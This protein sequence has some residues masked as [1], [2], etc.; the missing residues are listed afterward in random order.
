MARMECL[1]TSGS[2]GSLDAADRIGIA[3]TDQ[4]NRE[5]GIMEHHVA[6]EICQCIKGCNLKSPSCEDDMIVRPDSSG[7]CGS[8]E[9]GGKKH[10][11]ERM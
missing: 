3:P 9:R 7:T 5:K 2:G 4:D 8:N 10:L 1:D 11:L 6:Q